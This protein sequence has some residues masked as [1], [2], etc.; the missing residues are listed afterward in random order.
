M[1]ALPSSDTGKHRRLE[2]SGIL[3]FGACSVD[4]LVAMHRA[5]EHS[6]EWVGVLAAALVGFVAADFVSGFAHWAGDTLCSEQT[7]IV[8]RAFVRPFREHHVDPKAITRHDFV[9]TNGNSALVASPVL[10]LVALLIPET[11]HVGFYVSLAFAF[12]AWFTLCTNQFHKWAHADNAPG[13]V[14]GLQRARVILSPEH[15]GVHHAAPH[16]TYFCI[17]AGWLNPLLHRIRFFRACERLV[18]RFWPSLLAT[19]S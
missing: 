17:T 12:L 10:L 5:V 16:D 11:T 4:I 9:E 18:A 13:W 2:V 3:V 7:P 14:K 19:K 1:D 15:H 6:S 8:G